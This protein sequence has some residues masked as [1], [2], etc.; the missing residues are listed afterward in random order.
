MSR[1]KSRIGG[2]GR[3]KGLWRRS[4]QYS[5]WGRGEREWDSRK[6]DGGRITQNFNTERDYE[7]GDGGRGAEKGKAKQFL[8]NVTFP[9]RDAEMARVIFPPDNF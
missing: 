4:L 5:I 2:R 6:G 3:R 7:E 9:G 1:R 8:S